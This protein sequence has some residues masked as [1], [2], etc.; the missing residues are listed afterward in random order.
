MI[1]I[2]LT[3]YDQ[4]RRAEFLE[5]FLEAGGDLGDPRCAPWIISDTIELHAE[6]EPRD[7]GGLWWLECHAPTLPDGLLDVDKTVAEL[8]AYAEQAGLVEGKP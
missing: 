3:S 2:D 5:G 6:P 4:D 1:T 8:V 7:A